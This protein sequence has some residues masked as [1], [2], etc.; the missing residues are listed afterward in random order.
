[1]SKSFAEKKVTF[2][3]PV[4]EAFA[5]HFEAL[6]WSSL[7]KSFTRTFW[8]ILESVCSGFMHTG[9]A[10]WRLHA[11]R[12]YKRLLQYQS[13]IARF[14]G[15]ILQCF[16]GCPSRKAFQTCVVEA[17][18]NDKGAN[19]D[20]SNAFAIKWATIQFAARKFLGCE[21]SRVR[22]CLS[23]LIWDNYK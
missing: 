17:V 5:D 8:S 20:A 19:V 3:N 12:P 13:C 14:V 4:R 11:I 22:I 23:S 7:T 18:G 16:G 9:H 15:L 2:A 10:R 1:M 6:W 21:K